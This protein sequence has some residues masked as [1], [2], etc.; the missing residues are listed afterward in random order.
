MG[1]LLYSVFVVLMG[2]SPV[3]LMA[4]AMFLY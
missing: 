4:I 2:L 1:N 3:I